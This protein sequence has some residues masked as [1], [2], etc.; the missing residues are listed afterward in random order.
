MRKHTGGASGMGELLKGNTPT[1]I[2]AVLEG[3]AL[4]GYAIAREIE[5]RSADTLSLGEGSLYLVLRT[6]ERENFVTSEW[7]PQ[8]SGPARRVYNLT[9]SGR[10]E[11]LRREHNWRAFADA[12]DRVLPGRIP[13]A[14]LS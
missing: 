8:P 1:L 7:E 10:S 2:L 9:T 11:L 6:L 12:V 5:K 3:G 14:S 13:D 4:H